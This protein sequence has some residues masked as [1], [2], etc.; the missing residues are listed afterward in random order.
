M[1]SREN[2][3]RAAELRGPE[4][5]PC[6]VG[7][8]PPL[9]HVYREELEEVVLRHPSI[10]G[11]YEPGSRDFDDFGIRRRG[12]V[13][14]DEWGCV[15]HYLKDGL[16]GQAMEHPLQNWGALKSYTPP[17]PIALNGFPQEG[18]PR[19]SPNFQVVQER[20]RDAKRRGQLT[21]GSCPHGFM[22]QRLY[23]LRG[24]RNLM[25]DF[26]A[27]PPELQKLIDMV[28]DYNMKLINKWLEIGVDVMNFGDD[29][30]TQTRLTINPKTFRK[31]LVPAYSKMFG[32]VRET[33]THV[34]LHSDGYLLEVSEDL[35]KAGVTILNPQD[36]V[37]GIENLK[38]TLKG[39]VCIDLD[40]DRQRILP[41]GS[42]KNV[43]NH[44]RNAVKA[45][46][47]PK[48]GLM[49]TVGIYPPTPLANIEA[50][51]QTIEE[52][53]GGPKY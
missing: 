12:N 25:I 26:V 41:F 36:L 38:R 5:I 9:W 40:I 30:G 52:L 42:P 48:G 51:C 34:H 37:H 21:V 43:K 7:L 15:W 46:Y 2:Y 1:D 50:L 3:L 49:I 31:H 14:T 20:I 4:W 39:K 17:D 53:G 11:E 24:F 13:F 10:F 27:E 19:S 28:L 32:A 35:I 33:G 8:T 6:S 47:S 23:Y 44:V 45:L 16:Q 22:F 29:L 18:G